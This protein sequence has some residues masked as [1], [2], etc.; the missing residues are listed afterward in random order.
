[1]TISDEPVP[2]QVRTTQDQDISNPTNLGYEVKMQTAYQIDQINDYTVIPI[3]PGVSMFRGDQVMQIHRVD[4]LA[5]TVLTDFIENRR[6]VVLISK[7]KKYIGF[8]AWADGASVELEIESR[9][10]FS[11]DEN[12]LMIFNHPEFESFRVMQTRFIRK[13]FGWFKL[14]GM[15]P[16]RDHRYEFSSDIRVNLFQIPPGV[17]D[18]L[19]CGRLAIVREC[20]NGFDNAD[21]PFCGCFDYIAPQ[22]SN[23]MNE[24]SSFTVH[25]VHSEIMAKQAKTFTLKDISLG[26][27]GILA[28]MS[29]LPIQRG[30]VF[31]FEL[32]IPRGEAEMHISLRILGVVRHSR[33]MESGMS[34]LNVAWIGRLSE[35]ILTKNLGLNHSR[36][37]D[38]V[39]ED[40]PPLSNMTNRYKTAAP[41]AIAEKSKFWQGIKD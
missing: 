23:I 30:S 18:Y 36:S 16:R 8:L 17:M 26:G 15:D 29:A 2:G 27:I 11:R 34:E 5:P 10:Q 40:T 39:P 32:E 37:I 31:F 25:P 14:E 21:K 19:T 1:M 20:V 6:P 3:D 24:G 7:H 12:I 35:D 38:Q 28:P 33:P 41:I 4:S 9:P 22:S 13:S